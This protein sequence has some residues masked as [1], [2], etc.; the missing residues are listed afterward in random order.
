M[1]SAWSCLVARSGW[2]CIL[3]IWDANSGLL[4]WLTTKRRFLSSRGPGSCHR[5]W[6]VGLGPQCAHYVREICRRRRDEMNGQITALYTWPNRWTRRTSSPPSNERPATQRWHR[7]CAGPAGALGVPIIGPDDE[8]ILRTQSLNCGM[9]FPS[10][11]K[12]EQMRVLPDLRGVFLGVQLFLQVPVMHTGSLL[13]D[14]HRDDT[15]IYQTTLDR[16]DAPWWIP[17]AADH[18][19]IIT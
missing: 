8:A 9:P 16:A 18:H 3:G 17:D 1:R 5:D 15:S 2:R 4:S 7:V 10:R 12:N 11:A 19:T 6:L 14:T 13:S